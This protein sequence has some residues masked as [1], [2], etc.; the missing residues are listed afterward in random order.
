MKTQKKTGKKPRTRF[1]LRY[2]QE[3]AEA[4]A[5]QNWQLREDVSVLV[6]VCHGLL[7]RISERVNA[8]A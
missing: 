6:T 4:L 8:D 1:G 3:R 2:H 7:L 5:R